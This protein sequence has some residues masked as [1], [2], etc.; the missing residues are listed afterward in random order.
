MV[1]PDQELAYERT[2]EAMKKVAVA[3]S[4][5]A[6]DAGIEVLRLATNV[7][8]LAPAAGLAEAAHILLS[9]WEGVQM[10]EVRSNRSTVPS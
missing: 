6:H 4:D 8:E 10:V 7:L 9:I 3:F 2:K 1:P 5:N